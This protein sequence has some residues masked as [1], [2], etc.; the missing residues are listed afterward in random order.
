MGIITRND[1]QPARLQRQFLEDVPMGAGVTGLA[2]SVR[3]TV[4]QAMDA[5]SSQPTT[6]GGG[7]P[8]G[9]GGPGAGSSGGA[10]VGGVGR[11]GSGGLEDGAG[12]AN[13]LQR[14]SVMR[15]FLLN[16]KGSFPYQRMGPER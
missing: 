13:Q 14:R 11:S 6:S 4:W 8:G 7:P 15:E 5:F 1:L 16:S 3:G 12:V 2:S 9:V 10:G